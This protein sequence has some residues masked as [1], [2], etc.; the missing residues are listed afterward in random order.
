MAKNVKPLINNTARK[1]NTNRFTASSSDSGSI[2]EYS[3]LM[4]AMTLIML[5]IEMYRAQIPKSSGPYKRV[6]TGADRIIRI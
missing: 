5:V 3:Y 2:I 6:N 4:H 1:L